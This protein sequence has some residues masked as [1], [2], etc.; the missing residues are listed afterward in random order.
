MRNRSFLL[1]SPLRVKIPFISVDVPI[2]FP[3]T[4]TLTKGIGSRSVEFNNIPFTSNTWD[5]E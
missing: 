4:I 5:I 1:N 3:K 2:P